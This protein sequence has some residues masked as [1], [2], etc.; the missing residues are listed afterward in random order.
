ALEQKMIELTYTCLDV[1]SSGNLELVNEVYSPEIIRHWVGTP[2]V[3]G[4][5]AYREEIRLFK[6]A[7]PDL[8]F[9]VGELFVHGDKVYYELTLT[10]TNTGPWGDI[11][12]TGKKVYVEFMEIDRIVDNKIVEEWGYMNELDFVMQLGFT[13]APPEMT[14]N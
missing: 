7:F 10:G 3:I 5:D 12:P 6:T 11:P 9:E 13:L 4:V 8:H 1:W 14:D 2:D